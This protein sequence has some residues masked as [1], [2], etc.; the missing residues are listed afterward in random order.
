MNDLLNQ[1]NQSTLETYI[2]KIIDEGISNGSISSD[3]VKKSGSEIAISCPFPS[4]DDSN[5]SCHINVN[6]GLFHCKGCGAEF[7]LPPD[8]IS[9]NCAYCDSPYVVSLEK[10]RELRERVWTPVEPFDR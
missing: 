7:I 10:S 9:T 3:K 5:P 6:T 2:N 8:V 1:I 4:H